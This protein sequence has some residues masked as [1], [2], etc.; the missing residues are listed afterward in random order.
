MTSVRVTK[1]VMLPVSNSQ[2]FSL[3]MASSAENQTA[4]LVIKLQGN[5]QMLHARQGVDETD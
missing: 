3:H 5:M 1:R 4:M 2:A